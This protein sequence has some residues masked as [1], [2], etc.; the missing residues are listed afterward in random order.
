MLL[1]QPPVC[2]QSA[3]TW[4]V[5]CLTLT[6]ALCVQYLDGATLKALCALNKPVRAALASEQHI[7]SLDKPRFI[8]G[9]GMKTLV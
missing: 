9:S 7:Y 1:Q 6:A 5:S 3:H 8:H 2:H 4:C